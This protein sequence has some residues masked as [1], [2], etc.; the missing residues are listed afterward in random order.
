MFVF[1]SIVLFSSSFFRFWFYNEEK[2]WTRKCVSSNKRNEQMKGWKVESVISWNRS[3]LFHTVWNYIQHEGSNRTM[4]R[5]KK[6]ERFKVIISRWYTSTHEPKSWDTTW[7]LFNCYYFE[8]DIEVWLS[9]Y[10]TH[11]IIDWGIFNGK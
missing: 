9:I 6:K 1:I 4:N 11:S 10:E 3:R 2:H 5:E 8:I 7:L